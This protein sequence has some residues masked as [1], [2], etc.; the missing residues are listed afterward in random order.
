MKAKK[1]KFSFLHFLIFSAFI[2]LSIF[3]VI[4][5]NSLWF[6]SPIKEKK[7]LVKHLPLKKEEKEKILKQ[8]ITKTLKNYPKKAKNTENHVGEIKF[9]QNFI[10]AKE[11]TNQ[12]KIKTP[13]IPSKNFKLA[14][15]KVNH[16][17]D[18][19]L[20]TKN[21][22][23]FLEDLKIKTNFIPE[24]FYASSNKKY[25]NK[26]E[27]ENNFNF[28]D[29]LFLPESEKHPEKLLL[30]KNL[31]KFTNKLDEKVVSQPT[32]QTNLYRKVT[33]PTLKDL[34]TY[35]YEDDFEMEISY[36]KT[37]DKSYIFAITLIPKP[38]IDL[39]RIPQQ[40]TFLIDKSNSIQKNRLKASRDATYQAI[41]ILK[42]EDSFNVIAF[43]NKMDKLFSQ[44]RKLSESNKKQARK[45]L[46]NLKLG[47]FFSS[48]NVYNSLYS[49]I[50]DRANEHDIHSIILISNGDGLTKKGLQ[51]HFMGQW[52]GFNAGKTS[53][54]GV[55]MEQDQKIAD[56]EVISTLNR[57]WLVT[58]TT[59]GGLK[60]RLTKLIKDIQNPIIKDVECSYIS[61]NGNKF[62]LFKPHKGLP[63][64]YAGKPYVIIGKCDKLENFTLVL[65]G[66]N[67][68]KWLNIKKK[69]SFTSSKSDR[70]LLE[71]W[72]LHKAWNCY[73]DYLKEQKTFHLE[74][75]RKVLK[76]FNIPAAFQ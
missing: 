45:F 32:K 18:V 66:Q 20:T 29:M 68:D 38:N 75:A 9:T 2:H 26:T 19:V 72:A 14:D 65:Q 49:S 63:H 67:N 60:R 37:K 42:E 13:T 55:S 54:F 34:K 25:E 24:K 36:V 62:E 52:T 30:D 39:P 15:K 61:T 10:E 44:K 71:Q 3:Y 43:D 64:L 4:Q 28:T 74:K 6:Y 51:H 21:K 5:K 33:F 7:A 56:L 16:N 47:S 11:S 31:L 41:S 48:S 35:L 59:K 17:N 22:E 23:K 1:T 58:S 8:F 27:V 76:P 70:V 69:I 73:A 12:L 50:Y 53:L 46:M 57:G 40:F